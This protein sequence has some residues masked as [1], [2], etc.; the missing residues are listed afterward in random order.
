MISYYFLF[1]GLPVN[2]DKRINK[3]IITPKIKGPTNCEAF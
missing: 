1:N 2:S 3:T